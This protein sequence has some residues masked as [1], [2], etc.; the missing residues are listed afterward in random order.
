MQTEL[1]SRMNCFI[2]DTVKENLLNAYTIKEERMWEGKC[3]DKFYK[4]QFDPLTKNTT[5]SCI[6]F[7]FRGII[8]CHSLLVFSQED[9]YSVPSKYVL[10]R[11]SK[12]IRRRHTLIRAAYSNSNHEPTM[13]RYQI[14]CKR[15]YEIDEVACESE[16]AS[17]ELEKELDFLGKRFG[18]NSSMT[19]NIISD[20][21]EL[22]YDNSVSGTIPDTAGASVDVLVR[23]P[24]AVKRKERPRTTMFKST[25]AKRTKKGKFA[26]AKNT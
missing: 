25:V 12:N 14:L 9:V 18:Y 3:V 21:G 5:C 23:N 16:V 22:R 11:W 26:S 1:R 20:G 17:N 4:V 6:L 7:E 15:F 19:N 24:L 10:R 13:Q 2:K 8:C